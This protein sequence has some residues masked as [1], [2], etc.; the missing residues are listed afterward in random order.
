MEPS[1][2]QPQFGDPDYNLAAFRRD[3]FGGRLRWLATVLAVLS[4]ALIVCVFSGL[5][6]PDLQWF[7]HATGTVAKAIVIGAFVFWS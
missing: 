3:L 1:S 2:R 6:P 4:A 7:I 5:L